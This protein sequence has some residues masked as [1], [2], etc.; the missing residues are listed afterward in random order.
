VRILPADTH[1][2]GKMRPDV[3]NLLSFN[4]SKTLRPEFELR[5]FNHPSVMIP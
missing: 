3:G 1:L 2:G 4:H 5:N